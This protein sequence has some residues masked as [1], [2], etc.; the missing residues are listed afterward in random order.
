MK[1]SVWDTY[2]KRLDGKDMHFDILVPEGF[3][4]KEKVLQYGIDYLKGKHFMTEKLSIKKCQFCHIEG[5]SIA[6]INSIS[7]KGYDIVELENCN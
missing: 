3:N 6:T 1:I 5:A 2:V 7:E 4:N